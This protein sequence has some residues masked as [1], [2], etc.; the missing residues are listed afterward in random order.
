MLKAVAIFGV[1]F[2]S[3]IAIKFHMQFQPGAV[4]NSPSEWYGVDENELKLAD[5]LLIYKELLSNEIQL[6]STCN[7]P[8]LNDF[9]SDFSEYKNCVK[10]SAR[11]SPR[12]SKCDKTEK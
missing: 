8:K 4:D 2:K 5:I 10:K 12:R 11:C 9:D 6:N 1:L 7:V 3:L